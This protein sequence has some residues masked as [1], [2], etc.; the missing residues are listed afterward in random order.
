MPKTLVMRVQLVEDTEQ[1]GPSSPRYGVIPSTG[2]PGPVIRHRPL[3]AKT[4][5]R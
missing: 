5:R 4:E 3:P 2:A 1:Y